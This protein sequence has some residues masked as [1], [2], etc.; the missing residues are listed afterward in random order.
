MARMSSDNFK[1]EK[2]EI[3]R[4]EVAQNECLATVCV[5]ERNQCSG[6]LAG[7]LYINACDCRRGNGPSC[8][9]SLQEQLAETAL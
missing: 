9:A 2:G 7:K 3:W 8:M 5:L 6:Q 1:S 4:P